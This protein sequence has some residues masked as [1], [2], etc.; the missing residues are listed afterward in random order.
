MGRLA[1]LEERRNR[2]VVFRYPTGTTEKYTLVDEA[3][4][5]TV[6]E[7]GAEYRY[8]IQLLEDGEGDRLI[9]M[10]Y[11]RRPLGGDE[12]SWVFAGQTSITTSL[13]MWAELFARAMAADWFRSLVEQARATISSRSTGT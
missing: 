12:F 9:R 7:S 6:R 4:T 8:M 3:S 11:Y 5:D 10:T 13:G 1:D 2:P